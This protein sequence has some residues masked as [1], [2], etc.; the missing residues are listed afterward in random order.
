MT[1]EHHDTVVVDDRGSGSGM[2]AIIG[3]I[4]IVVLLVAVCYFALGPGSSPSGSTTNNNNTTINPPAA[5]SLEV[6]A[7]S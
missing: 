6:P 5:P 4:A 1:N 7:S 2:G 3:I